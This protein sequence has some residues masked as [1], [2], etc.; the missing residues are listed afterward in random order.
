M[1]EKLTIRNFGPIE[2][3]TLNLKTVTVLIG[4]QGTGKSTIA[5]VMNAVLMTYYVP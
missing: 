2:N 5:K 1:T 3:V 4:D